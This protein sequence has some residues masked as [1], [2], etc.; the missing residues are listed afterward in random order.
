MIDLLIDNRM[1][2]L[3]ITAFMLSVA[4][5]SI[6]LTFM[7]AW[8]WLMDKIHNKIDKDFGRHD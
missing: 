8:F 7:I 3:L 2:D 5:V 6:A 1:I 4:A